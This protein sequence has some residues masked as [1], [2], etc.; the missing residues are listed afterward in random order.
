MIFNQVS[1]SSFFFFSC[2]LKILSGKKMSSRLPQRPLTLPL[3][4]SLFVLGLFVRCL[5]LSWS[6]LHLIRHYRG[7]KKK[8]M[9]AHKKPGKQAKVSTF[10]GLL[11]KVSKVVSTS[12]C[13][14]L[15]LAPHFLLF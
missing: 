7:K 1:F 15:P 6:S 2:I 8:R 14:P 13:F 4:H 10:S 12:I 9:L 11:Q 5:F 3:M